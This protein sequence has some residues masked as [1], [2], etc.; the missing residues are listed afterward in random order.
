MLATMQ[1]LAMILSAR[2]LALLAVIGAF[3]LTFMAILDPVPLKLYLTFG[4]DV[5]VLVPTVALYWQRG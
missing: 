1:A 4:F 3:V 5:F 2:A